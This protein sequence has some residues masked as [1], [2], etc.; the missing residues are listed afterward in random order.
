MIVP[1]T[2]SGTHFSPIGPVPLGSPLIC[3]KS[4]GYLQPLLMMSGRKP[5][6]FGDGKTV[7]VERNVFD[8]SITADVKDRLCGK[9]KLISQGPSSRVIVKVMHEHARRLMTHTL[10]TE[11]RCSKGLIVF[12]VCLL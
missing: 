11:G 8:A 1:T 10:Q 5:A 6:C 9:G 4:R 2:V 3:S 7:F 12:I